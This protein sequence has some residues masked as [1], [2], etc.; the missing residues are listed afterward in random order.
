M[1]ET[2]TAE[3]LEDRAANGRY[4][5]VYHVSRDRWGVYDIDDTDRL[6]LW[7]GRKGGTWQQ[8]NAKANALNAREQAVR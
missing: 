7:T 4:R 2:P 1:Y 5:V 8:A 3:W 6:E